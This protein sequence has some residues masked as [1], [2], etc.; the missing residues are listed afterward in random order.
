MGISKIISVK[1]NEPWHEISNNV[2]C[3]T[4]KSSDQSDQSL[5]LVAGIFWVLNY[6]PN[7][8]WSF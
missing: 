2:I 7:I 4:S 8:I 5:L 3:E 1:I 6:W